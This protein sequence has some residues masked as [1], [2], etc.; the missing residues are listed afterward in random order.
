MT[1]KKCECGEPYVLVGNVMYTRHLGGQNHWAAMRKK[2]WV[3]PAKEAK[4]VFGVDIT[5]EEKDSLEAAL[6][7]ARAL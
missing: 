1:L 6:A 7:K 3:P 2:G 4:E 5:D